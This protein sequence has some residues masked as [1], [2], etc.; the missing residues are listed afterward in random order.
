MDQTYYES[1]YIADGY[2][3]TVIDSGSIA[4]GDAFASTLVAVIADDTGYYI[5]DYITDGYYAPPIQEASAALSA[6]ASIQADATKIKTAQADFGLSVTQNAQASR[7]RNTTGNLDVNVTQN[8][9]AL[10]IMQ[11]GGEFTAA[12]APTMTV[13]VLKNHTAILDSNFNFDATAVA[14]KTDSSLLEYFANLQSQGDRTR[15]GNATLVNT[16]QANT[17]AARNR[18]YQSELAAFFTAATSAQRTRNSNSDFD[19]NTSLTATIS[20]IEGVDISADTFATVQATPSVIKS[21]TVTLANTAQSSLDITRLRSATTALQAQF[22]TSAGVGTIKQNTGTFEASSAVSA[23]ISHIEGVDIVADAFA[24]ISTIAGRI[25][26]A[27]C[28]INTTATSTVNTNR[29]KTG[30]AQLASEFA[31]TQGYEFIIGSNVVLDTLTT[32]AS[33]FG[34]T[35]SVQVGTLESNV[36]LDDNYTTSFVTGLALTASKLAL[37]HHFLSPERVDILDRTTKQTLHSF[38]NPNSGYFDTNDSFGI[39]IAL[40]DNYLVVGAPNEDANSSTDSSGYA[41]V[42]DLVQ[43]QLL[44]TIAN[45]N[46]NLFDGFGDDVHIDDNYF[47][48]GAFGFNARYVNIYSLATGNLVRTISD[49]VS[50]SNTFYGREIHSDSDNLLISAYQYADG[51]NNQ[52]GRAYLYSIS[53]GNLIHTFDNPNVYGTGAG[54]YFGWHAG[55]RGDTIAISALFEDSATGTNSGRVYVYNTTS[56]NLIYRLDNPSTDDTTSD[57]FGRQVLV[58][59]NHIV[60]GMSGDDTNGS[61]SGKTYVFDKTNGDLVTTIT[62][63]LAGD[64]QGGTLSAFGNDFAT[65]YRQDFTE[66]TGNVSIYSVEQTFVEQIRVYADATLNTSATLASDAS[67]TRNTVASVAAYADLTATFNKIRSADASLAISTSASALNS[68]TRTTSAALNTTAQAQATST[69]KREVQVDLDTSVSTQANVGTI[70]QFEVSLSDAFNSTLSADALKNHTAI[71]DSVFDIEAQ[72]STVKGVSANT[73]ALVQLNVNANTIKA[74]SVAASVNTTLAGVAKITRNNTADLTSAFDFDIVSDKLDA[75]GATLVGTFSLTA[76][77]NTLHN[78][79]AA[80]VSTVSQDVLGGVS[81]DASAQLLGNT[82]LSVFASIPHLNQFV[83]VIPQENRR[84]HITRENRTHTITHENRIYSI[85]G[86]T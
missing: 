28:D 16:A 2:Y 45:P 17:D 78:A 57:G 51:S 54:D 55:I 35:A 34:L 8:A 19:L 74:S 30:S 80:L 83:Y 82:D 42:Y 5:P 27:H 24:S 49:P 14:T 38:Q 76:Q 12:F 44:Y 3:A 68:V 52:S 75:L 9:Q 11:I 64:S 56:G 41:Y 31:F 22:S 21:S 13:S 63:E 65:V 60:V 29:I 69:V 66:Q 33:E 26:S 50:S 20:H 47:Y 59:D 85:Q 39:K 1:G 58:L 6:S 10:K 70:K 25:Q 43:D 18:D 71:L 46:P 86:D 62:G 79:G 81:V 36:V 32:L 77:L 61:N 4:L 23:T 72:A 48:I 67:R 7:T 53:S 40:N 73:S 15:A 84:A 37:G